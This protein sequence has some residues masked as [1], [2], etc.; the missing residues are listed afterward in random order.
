MLM[1]LYLCCCVNNPDSCG[2]SK[3]VFIECISHT[4]LGLLPVF[5]RSKFSTLINVI[6]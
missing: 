6:Y 5:G 3:Q 1:A 2:Q 4:G